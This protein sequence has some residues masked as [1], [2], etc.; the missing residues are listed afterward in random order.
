MGHTD[1]HFF[2]ALF[3]TRFYNFV[4]RNDKAFA[5][6]ER[7]ALLTDIFSMQIALQ[8]FGRREA[9][10]DAFFGCVV[11]GRNRTVRF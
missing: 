8:T 6:L 11:V 5:A 4:D 10:K 7:E 1:D 2:D 9:L 3:G